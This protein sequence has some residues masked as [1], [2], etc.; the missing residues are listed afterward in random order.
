MMRRTNQLASSARLRAARERFWKRTGAEITAGVRE[1]TFAEPDSATTPI[2]SDAEE[3][4]VPSGSGNRVAF[5]EHDGLTGYLYVLDLT[6]DEVTQYLQVY[7]CAAA[8]FEVREPEVQVVWSADSTKCGVVIWGEMRGIIDL[9]KNLT[10][11]A[12]VSSRHS[13]GINDTE[14]LRGFPGFGGEQDGIV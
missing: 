9:A 5:F 6:A 8:E 10:G 4:T 7:T 3:F 11:R 1:N 13:P 12:F 2:T 14:W